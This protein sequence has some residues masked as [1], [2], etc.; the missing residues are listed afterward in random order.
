VLRAGPDFLHPR[1]FLSLGPLGESRSIVET[2]V[3][4]RVSRLMEAERMHG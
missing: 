1:H 2:K 4:S 3:H